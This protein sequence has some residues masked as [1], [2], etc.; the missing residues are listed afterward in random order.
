MIKKN[1]R[2]KLTKKCRKKLAE[3]WSKN[4]KKYETRKISRFKYFIDIN[5]IIISTE[6]FSELLI[7]KLN[8]YKCCLIFSCAAFC[9]SFLS[10]LFFHTFPLADSR[11]SLESLFW[12]WLY[13]LRFIWA[14]WC[15]VN[16][17]TD[18][19]LLFVRHKV[20][21]SENGIRK[22]THFLGI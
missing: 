14:L 18:S 8:C 17:K 11:L 20:F 21:T 22:V 3:K 13:W 6:S 19:I 2:K 15:F 10:F 5:R 9:S 4:A 1:G 7:F 16:G 12:Y